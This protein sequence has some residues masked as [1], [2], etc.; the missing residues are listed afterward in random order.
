MAS[1]NKNQPSDIKKSESMSSKSHVGDAANE[2]LTESKKLA[3][4]IYE[5]GLSK[6]SEAEE[7]IKEYSELVLKKIKDKPLTSIL[8]AGGVGFL[9]SKL[10]KK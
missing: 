6:V 9:L 1:L 2:L 3:S 8:I 4:E 5:E 7:Q 10:L